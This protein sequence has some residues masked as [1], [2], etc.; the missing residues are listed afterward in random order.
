M[1]EA[2]RVRMYCLDSVCACVWVYSR[3]WI[4]TDTLDMTSD[5]DEPF[6]YRCTKLFDLSVRKDAKRESEVS[7]GIN[8]WLCMLLESASATRKNGA[9]EGRQELGGETDAPHCQTIMERTPREKRCPT[10]LAKILI[11]SVL[12]LQGI[13]CNF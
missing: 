1:L 11:L 4:S 13:A 3:L 2:G 7:R 8:R 6:L 10:R 12:E 5:H 9:R